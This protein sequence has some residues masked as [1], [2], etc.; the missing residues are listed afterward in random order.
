MTDPIADLL[1]RI[2]NANTRRLESLT[3]P[4][5]RMKEGIVAILKGRGFIKD[6]SVAEVGKKRTLTVTLKFTRGRQPVIRR[7]DRVSRPGKRLYVR[8]SALPQ[9]RGGLGVA[10]LSTPRG[11]LTG[12]QA[13]AERVGGEYLCRVW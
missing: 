12:D 6:Y 7:L 1:T 8:A 4:S 2:R 13:R 3:L 10:I 5:S 9:V 11:I